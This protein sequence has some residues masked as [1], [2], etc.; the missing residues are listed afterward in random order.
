MR[1]GNQ[2]CFL[3][4]R[5]MMKKVCLFCLF[6]MAWQIIKAQQPL[7]PFRNPGLTIQQRVEDLLQKLTL[8]EKISLLG[9]RSQPVQ[10]LG[11]PA[12][13]WWNESLHGVARAGRATVFPQAIPMAASF[14]EPLMYEVASSISS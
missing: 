3:S 1:P 11:I 13:N 6:C 2:S 9:Y 12:Y 5:L 14:N 8:E 10:R 7:P 4:A